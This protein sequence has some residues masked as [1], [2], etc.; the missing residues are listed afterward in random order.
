MEGIR[1]RLD[2]IGS[3]GDATQLEEGGEQQLTESPPL[4]LVRQW[5]ALGLAA[6]SG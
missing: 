5:I 1:Q 6:A 4:I 2:T 3:I